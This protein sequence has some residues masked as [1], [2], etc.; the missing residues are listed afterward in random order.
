MDLKDLGWI[1]LTRFTCLRTGTYCWLL[2][3]LSWTL[4]T[5]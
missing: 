1:L 4:S 5:Y 3:R 2:W